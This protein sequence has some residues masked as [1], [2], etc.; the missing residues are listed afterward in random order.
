MEQDELPQEMRSLK[1][2]ER[3]A[4][5]AK[6]AAERETIQARIRQ[7]SEE[8]R[9]FVDKKEREMREADPNANTLDVIMLRTIREQLTARGLHF[10][11]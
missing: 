11:K 2:E 10:E 4:Y 1:P 7:L 9:H 3:E 5:V 8:R 6:K